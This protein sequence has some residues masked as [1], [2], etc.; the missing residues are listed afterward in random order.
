VTKRETTGLSDHDE[1]R[2]LVSRLPAARVK[3]IVTLRDRDSIQTAR[4]LMEVHGYSQLPVVTGGDDDHLKP[5]GV[6]TWESI[7]QALLANPDATLKECTA[8]KP[9][10]VSLDDELLAVIPTI[11][12]H[13]YV[14][15]LGSDGYISGIVTSADVGDTLVELAGPYIDLSACE[16]QLR[17]LLQRC[18]VSSAIT[19]QDVDSAVQGRAK[20]AGN[21]IPDLTLGQLVSIVK[22]SGVQATIA[23]HYDGKTLAKLLDRIAAARNAVMHFREL[24]PARQADLSHARAVAG[25]LH[26][27]TEALARDH[28]SERDG[29]PS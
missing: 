27:V 5:T 25:I 13:G 28:A 7:A 22:L 11:N 14:V 29:A 3:P 20:S 12:A 19:Q 1:T 24:P 10:E 2:L 18:L 6:V 21:E 15:V 9:P 23:P 26:R 16:R 8:R 17:L 4:T